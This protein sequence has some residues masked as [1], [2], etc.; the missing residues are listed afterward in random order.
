MS[1]RKKLFYLVESPD[2]SNDENQSFDWYDI[3]MMIAIIVSII[4]LAFKSTNSAFEIIDKVTVTIFIIDYIEA[5]KKHLF[6]V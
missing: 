5:L 3:T 1:L 6:Q 2:D 4:P